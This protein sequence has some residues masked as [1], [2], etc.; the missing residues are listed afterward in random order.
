MDKCTRGFYE[1]SVHIRDAKLLAAREGFDG[2]IG[3]LKPSGYSGAN[4]AIV[5]GGPAGMAAGYFLGRQGAKVTIFERRAELGGIVRYVIPGFRIGDFGIDRDVD[6]LKAMGA[7]IKTNTAAPSVAELKKSGYTHVIFATGAWEHGNLKLESGESM[8][9]LDFLEQYRYESLQSVGEHV[10]VVGGGNTAM[11]AARAAKRMK[12]VVSS[13]IVYRRTQRYMPADEEELQLALEDGVEFCELLNPV[14]L[15]DGKLKCRKCILGKPD[16]SGRLSSVETDEFVTLPCSLLI[17][18]IG[19]KIVGKDFTDNGITLTERGAVMVQPDTLETSEP[20]VFVIGDA[21]RG[22][23]TVVEAIAD[24]RKVADAIVGSYTVTVPEE[25]R[26]CSGN[27]LAKQG[28][29]AVYD[30]AGKETERCLA[31]STICECCVQVCPNRANIAIE[32]DKTSMPQIIHVDRMCNECGNCTVFC[33]YDSAPYKEKL[34]LFSTEKEFDESGNK[35]FFVLGGGKVKLRLG[36]VSVIKLGT[37]AIDPKIE[38]IINSV[39]WD[40]SYLL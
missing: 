6:L 38:Q 15:K 25:S 19:E 20:N 9:V 14:S 3:S 33:P 16:A 29:L 7:Q 39:I 12:G 34:T 17:S 30:S 28:S 40:Y 21:N 4:V 31:C 13:S 35:G 36:D 1:E 5:G 26:A 2:L 27:C 22:P 8:N 18:S 11:D 23:A 32:I 24:A 37:N 10:V